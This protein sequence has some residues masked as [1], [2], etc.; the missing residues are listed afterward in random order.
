[1]FE[2]FME[3]ANELEGGSLVPDEGGTEGQTK[4]VG[5]LV[6]SSGCM[7]I[8]S[9]QQASS[10]LVISGVWVLNSNQQILFS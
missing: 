10:S 4:P 9:R 3:K 8:C 6:P 7:Q 5:C 2:R 1:M